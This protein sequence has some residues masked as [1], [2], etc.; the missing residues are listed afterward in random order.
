M[1]PKSS[2]KSNKQRAII[3]TNHP[4]VSI[5][6]SMLLTIVLRLLVERFWSHLSGF[7]NTWWLSIIGT[8]IVLLVGGGLYLF[9][10]YYQM[11]FGLS[12]LGF[13]ITL[14]WISIPTAQNQQDPASWIRVGAAAYFIVRGLTNYFEGKEKA[15]A[16]NEFAD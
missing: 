16:E 10:K 5:V 7:W 2:T 15:L 12:E 6:L 14:C 9:R 1:S 3:F 13:A 8:L 4:S 11:D